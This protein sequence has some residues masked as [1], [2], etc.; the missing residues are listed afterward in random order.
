MPYAKETLANYMTETIRSVVRA[1]VLDPVKSA[2]KMYREPRIFEDLLSSQPLC[3]NLFGELQRDLDLAS[4]SMGTLLKDPGVRVTSVA[5][6]Q[7]PGRS[8]ARFTEDKSAF[9]V[10][11]ELVASDGS[12]QFVGIEVKYHEDL[13]LPPARHRSRYDEVANAMECFAVE[14]LPRLRK[15]PLEQLW[16]DHLLAGSLL[17]DAA[18]GF[19]H[20]TFA[21]VY[22]SENTPVVRAVEAYRACLTKRAT[23]AAWTLEQVLDAIDASRA[24]PW[25]R[26]VR[27]R[28]LG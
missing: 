2:G 19:A 9:D 11:V 14:S 6:E 1:E 12:R 17:L 27:G 21:I 8:D 26:E 3:F 7:S 25:A 10:F 23:F 28:Y 13:D 4:R 5:F 22:P 16:R 24:G 18:S 15:K 20:G